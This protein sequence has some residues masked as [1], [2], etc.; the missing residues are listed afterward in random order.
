MP[1]CQGGYDRRQDVRTR[2]KDITIV[3]H[4]F[5]HVEGAWRSGA[6]WRP[7][8]SWVLAV[9]TLLSMSV[10]GWCVHQ[11][12]YRQG[13][14]ELRNNSNAK[15]D[16]FAAVVEARIRRLEPVPATIQ[17]NP[18]VVSLL[19]AGTAQSS[20]VA[21]AND[22]LARLNAHVGSSS[23]F[24]IDVRGT[25]L[26]SS[27]LSQ[28]DDS[29][30]GENLAYRPYYLEALA[31]RAVRYAAVGSG[32]QLGYF[33]SHPIYDGARIVGVAVVKVA[34]DAVEESWAILAAPTL[35]VDANQIVILSSEPS[36]RMTSLAPLSVERRVD[37]QL[38]RTYGG[39]RLVEFPVDLRLAVNEDTQEVSGRVAAGQPL[40]GHAGDG[41]LTAGEYLILGRSLDGTDWRVMMFIDLAAVER[42]AWVDGAGGAMLVAFL[43][44]LLLYG[45]QRRRIEKQKQLARQILESANT[46]LESRVKQRTGELSEAVEQLRLEVREREQ[47]EHN[48][49]SA[50]AELVHAGKMAVLGQLAA[51][52]T[53]ELTQPLGGIRTLAGNSI[54]FMKR[55]Q[56]DVAQDNLIIVARLVD[57][58]GQ[59]ISPLKS[60]SRKSAA[61][62]VVVD[63]GRVLEQ[64]L[65]LFQLRI[66]QDDVRV[67]NRC[68][69]GSWYAWCDA[70]RLEQVLLN[71]IGNALDA[72]KD[73]ASRTLTV[74]VSQAEGV[75][76]SHLVLAV[77]DTGKGLT[78]LELSRAFEPFFT[79]KQDGAG[80]GL[81]LAICRDLVA[82]FNGTLSAHNQPTG[83]ACFVLTVPVP[84]SAQT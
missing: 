32:G 21:A 42:S 33:V 19:R 17:L 34:L 14:L 18:L 20:A 27:N 82:E 70:N 76:E 51:S 26:A 11:H 83:G 12:S 46:E 10:A 15:L 28:P 54:E 77:A 56:Q 38:A 74:E 4:S 25:V 39:L 16:L 64:A 49:R 66:R 35:V 30:L 75:P 47:T 22:Y 9:L 37:L 45:G 40:L 60:F 1:E 78:E 53:H 48:L 43:F 69:P 52:I 31:G 59:I 68:P 61:H 3:N 79:T 2:Q 62:P 57:Q 29:R 7:W 44:L 58:M 13:E 41:R 73:A 24:V 65:F 72:M 50:Q 63:V 67:D 71:L 84:N 23:V 80:L 81:G 8:L 5:P 6:R 55:G 36:W